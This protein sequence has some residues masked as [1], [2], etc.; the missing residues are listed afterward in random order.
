MHKTRLIC[1]PKV[2]V[3]RARDTP[4]SC[5]TGGDSK[6]LSVCVCRETVTLMEKRALALDWLVK[7]LL[8]SLKKKQVP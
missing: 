5:R 8:S 4:R 7:R 6:E 1:L 2:L 3:R